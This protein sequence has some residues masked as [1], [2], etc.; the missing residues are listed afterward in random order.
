MKH[1]TKLLFLFISIAAFSQSPWTQKDGKF[2]TQLSFTTI[3]NYN[4][5]FGDPEY[6]TERQIT[7]NTIQLY[8]E[9]G[10]SDKTTFIVNLPLKLI[11]T[12]DLS[13]PNSL[14]LPTTSEGNSTT[15]GNIELG[16]KHN[17]SNKNW[18][19]SGQFSIEANTGNYDNTTGIRTG[20]DAW[21][22]TPLFLAGKSFGKTYLQTFIGA[23]I[24][25]NDYSS[26]F[27]VGGELG[28]K[29]TKNIWLVGFLDIVKSLENGD[30]ILPNNNLATGLYVNNQEY[31]AFGLKGI[32]EF[33]NNYGVTASFGGAF[34]GNN[35]AKKAALNF[36]VYRKF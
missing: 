22:I 18:L 13:N 21:T 19:L 10:L 26:N 31:G 23:N 36:G 29:I 27:K 7:D 25:T 15:I 9:Y 12:G 2:F 24:R 35:V 33:S 30:V 17:F 34:F 14:G 32:T 6:A 4:T 28:Y 1:L 16:L 20:Y 11:K 3:S 5:L 8:S